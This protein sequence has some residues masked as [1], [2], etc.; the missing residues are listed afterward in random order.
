MIASSLSAVLVEYK[1]VAKWDGKLPQFQGA[2]TS[3]LVNP[4]K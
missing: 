3:F 2:G 1:R 4:T